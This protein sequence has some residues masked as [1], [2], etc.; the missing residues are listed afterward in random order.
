VSVPKGEG[1]TTTVPGPAPSRLRRLLE[2]PDA[3]RRLARAVASLLG[4]G[5]ATIGVIGA[6]LIWHLVR[7]G[8]LIREG[9]NPPRAVRL[10]EIEPT[11]RDSDER[12]R[13][14]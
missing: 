12:S 10:P 11:E 6:L 14:P 1:R 13:R 5:I 3:R 9:L 4:V 2:R 8:R 7:R